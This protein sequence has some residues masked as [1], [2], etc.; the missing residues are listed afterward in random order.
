MVFLG[1]QPQATHVYAL[2]LILSGILVTQLERRRLVAG[3]RRRL[4]R[5]A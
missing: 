1:E 5:S 3:L 2:G 4:K